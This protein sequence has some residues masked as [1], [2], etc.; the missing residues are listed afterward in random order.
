MDLS[1][2]SCRGQGDVGARLVVAD[3][4]VVVAVA[5]RDNRDRGIGV[6]DLSVAQVP[7]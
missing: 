2:A 4:L 1:Q 7:Q 6:R 3:L 5:D